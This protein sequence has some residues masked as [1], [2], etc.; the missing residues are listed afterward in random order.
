MKEPEL[1]PFYTAHNLV[2]TRIVETC[3]WDFNPGKGPLAEARGI[4]KKERAKWITNAATVWQVY[5]AVAGAV[6]DKRVGKSN[7]AAVVRGLVVDYDLKLGSTQVNKLLKQIAP[8]FQPQ[9]VETSLSQKIRLVWVFER[10]MPVRDSKHAGVLLSALIQKM[11]LHTLLPGY[12]AASAKAE[13]VWTNGGAWRRWRREPLAWKLVFGYAIDA[14]AKLP[15]AA[16]EIPIAAVADEVMTR[17]PDRW[18]HREF[19]LNAL[20]VRFWD[21]VADCPTGCQ[22]KPDGMLCFTGPAGFKSWRDLLENMRADTGRTSV[23]HCLP[24]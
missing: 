13:Q 12:D 17:W 6:P 2:D 18:Q 24:I 23:P 16:Q 20:G 10:P 22:V 7:P 19:K 5:S 15:S 3:P 11:K 14:F 4:P 21:P 8:E 1:R 9:F